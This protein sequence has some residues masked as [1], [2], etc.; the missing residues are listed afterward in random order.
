MPYWSLWV[1]PGSHC[2]IDSAALQFGEA[3]ASYEEW[4][5]NREDQVGAPWEQ[6]GRH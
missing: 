5:I 6:T 3:L 2:T 4:K 1:L